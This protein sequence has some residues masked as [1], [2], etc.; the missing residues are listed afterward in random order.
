MWKL[1]PSWC[2]IPWFNPKDAELNA[3]PARQDA[4]CIFCLACIS[5]PSRYA[6][7]K[8]TPMISIA[9]SAYAAE[10]SLLFVLTYASN[11]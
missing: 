3:R 10:N 4:A 11:A 7:S 5:L 6:R 8:N 2:A 1:E 9:F